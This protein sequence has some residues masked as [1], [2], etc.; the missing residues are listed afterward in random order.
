MLG[1][2]DHR[3][4]Q[5][6]QRPAP[7]ALGRV[8]A[9]G[10]HQQRLLLA[11]ELAFRAGARL[12]AERGSSLSAASSFSSTKRRLVRYTVD[13]PTA[14]LMAMSSSLIPAS[15]AKR[16]CARLSLRAACLPALSR[17]LSSS[18]SSLLNATRERTFTGA[19]R[20]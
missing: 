20:G 13:P 14:T 5:Q 12:L 17:A 16:I 1:E 6:L 7:A 10:R 11:R 19:P 3:P 15:A 8:G 2:R 18:R 9:G 4:G